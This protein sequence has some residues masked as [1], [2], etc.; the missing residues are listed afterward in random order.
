MMKKAARKTFPSVSDAL[1][2][3]MNL[4]KKKRLRSVS[5][6]AEVLLANAL[7]KDRAFIL[8][9]PEYHLKASEYIRYI[10]YIRERLRHMPVAYITEQKEFY[11]NSFF[12]NNHVLI[13]RPETELLIEEVILFFRQHP[14]KKSLLDVGTGSGCIAL[15]L[16][17]QIHSLQKIIA[18]DSSLAALS[19]AKKNAQILKLENRVTFKKVDLFDILKESF[20]CIVANLPYLSKKEYAQAKKICLEI[21]YEP[22]SALC[23]GKTGLELFEIFFKQVPQHLNPSG[24]IFLEIGSGQQRGIQKLVKTYLSKAQLRFVR[25]LSK[26]IRLAIVCHPE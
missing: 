17:Q 25:D 11:G 26:R 24:I 3:A 6:D 5:L 7:K 12:V 22:K 20:D 4:L 15:S 21:R 23:A 19:V 8:T 13:P 1:F 14:E 9:H 16:A 10:A 2:S 18:T